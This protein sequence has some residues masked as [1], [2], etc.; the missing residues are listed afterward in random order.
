MLRSSLRLQ[1]L[2]SGISGPGSGAT[3]AKLPDESPCCQ[4]P[5]ARALRS[6]ARPLLTVQFREASCELMLRPRL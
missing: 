5:A 1:G 2:V 6:P 4:N 3:I